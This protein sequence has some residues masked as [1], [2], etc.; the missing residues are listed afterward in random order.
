M[1]DIIQEEKK[2]G[3]LFAEAFGLTIAENFFST[4]IPAD[5]INAAALIFN[6][7]NQGNYPAGEIYTAQILG[8]YQQRADALSLCQ[9]MDGVLPLYSPECFIVKE[10]SAG[11]YF[12]SWNG[13]D[14]W[15][16]SMNIRIYVNGKD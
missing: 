14:A 11:V 6:G 3:R 5:K 9:K 10:G 8:R 16:V 7:S 15:G 1:G 13:K 12:T 2:I 4:Q